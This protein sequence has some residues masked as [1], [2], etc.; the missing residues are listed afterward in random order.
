MS[1]P[2][3][4]LLDRVVIGGGTPSDLSTLISELIVSLDDHGLKLVHIIV[5]NSR[6]L[7]ICVGLFFR[8]LNRQTIFL[9]ETSLTHVVSVFF[10]LHQ[11]LQC[12]LC[13]FLDERV[14]VTL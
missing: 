1:V 9:T 10:A 11:F 6:S 5:G 13:L 12:G 3:A 8:L 2:L 7:C 14:R 4:F